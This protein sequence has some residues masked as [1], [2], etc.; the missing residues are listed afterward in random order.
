MEIVLSTIACRE[1]TN[2]A[3]NSFS[4][5]LI[6]I[7]IA[8]CTHSSAV[9]NAKT[10]YGLVSYYPRGSSVDWE[11]QTRQMASQVG[12]TYYNILFCLF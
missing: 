1:Q 12:T 9:H 11:H 6:I 8:P 10:S 3:S 4:H 5:M 2:E 7:I